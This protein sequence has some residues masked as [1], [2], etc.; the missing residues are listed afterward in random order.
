M[1]NKSSDQTTKQEKQETIVGSK[2][3]EDD[4]EDIPTTDLT[5]VNTI[6]IM[7]TVSSIP[8]D[9]A[10][11]SQTRMYHELYNIINLL[12]HYTDIVLF[13]RNQ[14]NPFKTANSTQVNERV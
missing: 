6:D 3:K 13:Q 8:S 10:G 9:P 7:Q 12:V 5:V 4:K 2:I 14:Q 11:L 1:D